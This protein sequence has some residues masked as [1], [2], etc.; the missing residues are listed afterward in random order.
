MSTWDDDKYVLDNP[1]IRGLSIENIRGMFTRPLAGNYAPLHI[2]SYAFDYSLW[3]LNA[4]GYHLFNVILHGL[5]A[6]GAYTLIRMIT[7][8]G[9]MALI[10]ALLFAVHPVNVENVVWI[11]ERKTL[12]AGLF[13][14]PAFIS[15]LRFREKGAP[16]AYVTSLFL[17]TFALLSKAAVVTLPFQLLAYEI[18]FS[19]ER[20]RW[21][22]IV[23]FFI[24]SAVASVVAIWAQISGEAVDKNMLGSGILMET[25]C[26]TMATVFWKYVG[27]LLWPSSLSAFYDTRLYH[28]FLD[29]P[30]LLSLAGLSLTAVVVFWKGGD[31]ARFWFLWF[32]IFLLP[33]SNIIPLPVFYADRYL[34]LAEIGFFCFI[35]ASVAPALEKAGALFR[36]SAALQKKILPSFC[37]VIILAY[38]Y[39]AFQRMDVWRDGITFWEDTVRKSPGLYKPH[40]N[41]GAGYEVE[42]RF[43]EAE[44]EYLAAYAIWPSKEVA[45]NLRVLRGK[46]GVPA[47]R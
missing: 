33:V 43:S 5:N 37:A 23:P 19:R 12:L 17:Y 18:L 1:F 26:P 15:Y 7:G 31:Q 41:L 27:L 13:F 9:R 16:G 47:P 39:A 20:R 32:C 22:P 30:V 42:G 21:L 34:Y 24:L 29:S 8:S 25:V 11:S 3:G 10:S 2:L 36:T 40:L 38:G 28:S 14:F 46:M 35:L 6:C 44:R 45:W 4:H